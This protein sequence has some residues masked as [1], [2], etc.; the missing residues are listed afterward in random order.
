MK[1]FVLMFLIFVSAAAWADDKQ[2]Q[3]NVY[4]VFGEV[5]KPSASAS[6]DEQVTARIKRHM[7]NLLYPVD[8]S[9]FV[10]PERDAKFREL[11]IGLQKQ[12]GEPA[13]G[14]LTSGQFNRLA[15]AARD[16]DDRLIGLTPGKLIGRPDDGEW[17]SAVGTGAMDGIANPINVTR[18]FCLRA[19]STCEMSSAEFDLKYGMLSFG[20]P[21]VYE[22]KTWR[23]SRVTAIREHPCGTAS[24]TIDVDTKAV[25]IASVPHLDLPF[26]TKEPPSIWKLVDGFPVAW[27]IHQDKVNKAR[28]LVY[29]PARRLI[30]PVQSYVPFAET[31]PAASDTSARGDFKQEGQQLSEAAQHR[32]EPS[33]VGEFD[34]DQYLKD[35]APTG[36]APAVAPERGLLSP[37]GFRAIMEGVLREAGRQMSRAGYLVEL[38]LISMSVAGWF[39]G[40]VTSVRRRNW[41]MVTLEFFVPPIG[42][43]HGWGALIWILVDGRWQ[44]GG[45]QR[46][47]ADRS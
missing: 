38:A 17:L 46:A 14:I 24:M 19:D 35:T 37:E 9:S 16:I 20:S 3:R 23:P 2:D 44:G 15:E 8:M 45:T 1:K 11:V 4:D 40:L 27:K 47:S 41:F 5:L 21:A 10:R 28:A 25:T 13:T 34:P 39:Y 32:P 42:I 6:I 12:M 43:I 33:G 18:I 7:A 26:C 36:A 22:I 31:P 29:E 30:P